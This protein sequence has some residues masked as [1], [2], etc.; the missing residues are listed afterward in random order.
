MG[1]VQ[2]TLRVLDGADRGKVYENLVVPMTIGREEGNTIQLN[3]ERISRFHAKIQ[4]DAGKLV[5]TDLESTNGTRVNGESVK[6]WILRPGDLIEVGRTLLLSG[7]EQQI[8]AR[9]AAM[10]GA[11]LSSGIEFDDDEDLEEGE[12]LPSVRLEEELNWTDDPQ[13]RITL[14]TLL[15]PELPSGLSTGDQAQLN[16]L[17]HYLHFRIRNLLRDVTPEYKPD[18]PKDQVESVTISQR[19]WQDLL[20]IELR[21]STYLREIGDPE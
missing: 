4:E 18:G 14:H 20:D 19:R 9:L 16:E 11:D 21:L 10:R 6:L 1:S 2:T 7:N 3:D 17:L 13:A 12:V 15:P 8:A 5:L